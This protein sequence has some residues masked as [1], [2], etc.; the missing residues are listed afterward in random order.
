MG[1]FKDQMKTSTHNLVILLAIVAMFSCA[2]EVEQKADKSIIEMA[3]VPLKGEICF[4]SV[5]A[6]LGEYIHM[7]IDNGT[8][9][10]ELYTIHDYYGE[11]YYTFQGIIESDSIMSI[12]I[13]ASTTEPLVTEILNY[14]YDGNQLIFLTNI[15]EFYSKEFKI[16]DCV[17]MPPTDNYGTIEN[18]ETEELGEYLE[19]VFPMY[20][21]SAAPN[22]MKHNGGLHEYFRILEALDTVIGYGVG[23]ADGEPVWEFDFTGII[24]DDS[25]YKVNVNYRQEGSE[26]VL[27]QEVWRYNNN[28]GDFFLGGHNRPSEGRKYYSNNTTAFPAFIQDSLENLGKRLPS[29]NAAP[30]ELY[31]KRK[32]SSKVDY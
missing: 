14:H 5:D 26:P 10:G 21:E 8:F 20:Y 13:E 25:L 6:S 7:R 27:S 15:S 1:C 30:W 18:L 24:V 4:Q 32:E 11:L 17:E 2:T 3:T 23:I 12:E 22:A 19:N 16:M 31:E 29:Y 28:N 9:D